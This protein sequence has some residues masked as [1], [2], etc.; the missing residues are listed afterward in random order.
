MRNYSRRGF[1]GYLLALLHPLRTHAQVAQTQAA[2]KPSPPVRK[3]DPA[4][5]VSVPSFWLTLK[6]ETVLLGAKLSLV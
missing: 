5:G 3:G 4:I 2:A 1:A 6:P